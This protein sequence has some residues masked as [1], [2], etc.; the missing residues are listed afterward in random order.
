MASCIL[1]LC[2]VGAVYGFYMQPLKV[3]LFVL[4]L[5]LAILTF[6]HLLTLIRDDF[7]FAKTSLIQ[8]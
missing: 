3:A 1:S 8:S 6:I 4:S 5:Q 7:F 2:G